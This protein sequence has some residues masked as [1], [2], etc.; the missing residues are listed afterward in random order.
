MSMTGSMTQALVVTACV[1]GVALP[2]AAEANHA[3][4]W[5]ELGNARARLVAGAPAVQAAKAYL[6]GVQLTLAEGWKTYWRMPGDAGVPPAFD[7]SGSANVASVKVLY[8]APHR[9]HEAG[10]ESVGYKTSVLFPV[11]VV[12]KDASK[13]VGLALVMEL[14]ICRDI[15]IPAEAKISLQLQPAAMT[16]RPSPE[17][18]AA[19]DRVPRRDGARRALDPRVYSATAALNGPSPRLVIEAVFPRGS[20]AADAFVEAPDSLYVP[21]LKR[22][23]EAGGARAPLTAD[24]NDALVRFEADLSRTGNAKDLKGKTLT[25]TLVS[26]AGATE[27][28]WTLP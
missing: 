14:G 24:A 19:L 1:C 28:T 4:P 15:C 17:I 16:G 8:P 6:A 23:P 3:S 25:L 11:E 27:A 2:A 21:M 22:V 12:P 7:W 26:D 18:L 9:L 13:P 10:A 20:A 5:T